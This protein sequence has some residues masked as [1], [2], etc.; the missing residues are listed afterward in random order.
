M[1]AGHHRAVRML[2]GPLLGSVIVLAWHEGIVRI[3]EGRDRER[4][5]GWGGAGE[6][7]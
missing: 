3:E 4:E 7:G 6:A 1:P 2:V 5:A